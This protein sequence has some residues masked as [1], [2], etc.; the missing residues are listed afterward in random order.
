[1]PVGGTCDPVARPGPRCTPHYSSP[2]G[3]G[4]S[5]LGASPA[6]VP[7]RLL[8]AAA[9]LGAR[10][11]PTRRRRKC[12]LGPGLAVT[13]RSGRGQKG[14]DPQLQSQRPHHRPPPCF[15]PFLCDVT[16]AEF[17]VHAGLPNRFLALFSEDTSIWSLFSRKG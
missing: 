12:L 9:L 8:H 4:Q 14:R 3:G 11:P 2:S 6:Q 16:P 13:T 5:W 10:S 15:S 1:M 7:P 17:W